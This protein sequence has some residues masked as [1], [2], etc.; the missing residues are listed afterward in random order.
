MVCLFLRFSSEHEGVNEGLD[1][2]VNLLRDED[3]DADDDVYA[4]ER[5]PHEYSF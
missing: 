4:A 3:E 1:W 2:V 5:D